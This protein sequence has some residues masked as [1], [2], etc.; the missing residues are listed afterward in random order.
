VVKVPLFEL[1]F[2]S[3]ERKLVQKLFFFVHP[4]IDQLSFR[5]AAVDDILTMDP[6]YVLRIRYV[7]VADPNFSEGYV[8][9]ILFLYSFHFIFRSMLSMHPPNFAKTSLILS[10][11]YRSNKRSS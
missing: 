3:Y 10:Q 1:S 9:N 4:R 2:S 5:P 11:F 7:P 8:E 6:E